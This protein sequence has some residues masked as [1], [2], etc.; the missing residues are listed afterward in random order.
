MALPCLKERLYLPFY[1]Q[2]M[3][4]HPCM[5]SPQLTSPTDSFVMSRI[6]TIDLM[7]QIHLWKGRA[8]VPCQWDDQNA[9]SPEHSN[10]R[11]KAIHFQ[12]CY[13]FCKIVATEK[14]LLTPVLRFNNRQATK[15]G[16]TLLPR[17]CDFQPPCRSHAHLFERDHLH[18]TTGGSL[19]CLLHVR[20]ASS[21]SQPRGGGV[22]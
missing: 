19:H 11:R 13:F 6:L 20:W 10:Q 1:F 5:H 16:S 4:W 18:R 12:T 9:T 14:H 8:I 7:N 15:S 21:Y 22:G 17:V 2:H 3:Q